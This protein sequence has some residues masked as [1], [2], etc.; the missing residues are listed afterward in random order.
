MKDLIKKVIKEE[1]DFG[2][3]QEDNREV[4]IQDIKTWCENNR[5]QISEWVQKIDEFYKHTPQIDWDSSEPSDDEN[6]MIALSVMSIGHEL[7]NIYSSFDTI[8][9]EINYITNPELFRDEE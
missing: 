4:P 6:R 1:L 2:W 5:T 3:A 7:K 8:G 9:D